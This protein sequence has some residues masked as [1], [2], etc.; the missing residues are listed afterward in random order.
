L[1]GKKQETVLVIVLSALT[2]AFVFFTVRQAG[3][4]AGPS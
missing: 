1:T 2:A 4:I 3:F